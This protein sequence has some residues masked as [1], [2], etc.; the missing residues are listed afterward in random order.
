MTRVTGLLGLMPRTGRPGP[1]QSAKASVT[2][3]SRIGAGSSDLGLEAAA[4]ALV[5]FPTYDDAVTYL[6]LQ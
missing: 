5:V 1:L 2:T 3:G 6:A 4:L